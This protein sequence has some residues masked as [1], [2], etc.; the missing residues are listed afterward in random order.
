MAMAIILLFAGVAPAQTTNTNQAAQF[1]ITKKVVDGGILYEQVDAKGNV[2]NG[3]FVTLAQLRSSLAQNQ[4]QSQAI[5]ADLQDSIS[6]IQQAT[7]NK[8]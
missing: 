6:K 8:P 5:Q 3:R 1:T 2:V 7:T 4:K